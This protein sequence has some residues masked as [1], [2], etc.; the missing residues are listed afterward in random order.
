MATTSL[1]V[2]AW[3][4]WAGIGIATAVATTTVIVIFTSITLL[5][6]KYPMNLPSDRATKEWGRSELTAYKSHMS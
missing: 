1:T 6:S 5:D 4:V 3:G 2:S